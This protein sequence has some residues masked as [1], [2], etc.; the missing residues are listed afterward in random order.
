MSQVLRSD[1]A[2]AEVAATCPTGLPQ[3]WQKRAW[4]ESSAWQWLHTRRARLA[5]HPLQK[6]PVAGVPQAAQIAEVGGV[7]EGEA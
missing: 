3:R 4:G 7:M 1:F 2:P 6:L 5:P